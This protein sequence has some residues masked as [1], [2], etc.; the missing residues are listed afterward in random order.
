MLGALDQPLRV[1]PG[2]VLGD[3]LIVL[4][5]PEAFPQ[6]LS[7]LETQIR[8][9]SGRV[10]ELESRM[11]RAR[12]HRFLAHLRDRRER[13]GIWLAMRYRYWRMRWR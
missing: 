5:T 11:P 8:I 3:P 9:L 7:Y 1:S 2:P 12:W 10:A 13:L 4:S 6:R